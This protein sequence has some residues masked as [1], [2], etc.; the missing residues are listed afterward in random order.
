[1]CI[2]NQTAQQIKDLHQ[3]IREMWIIA[4]IADPGGGRAPNPKAADL[5]FVYASNA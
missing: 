2:A 1:M 3:Y 4:F 5:L